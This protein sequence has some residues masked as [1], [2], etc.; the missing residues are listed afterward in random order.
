MTLMRDRQV[1][2]VG[3][4]LSALVWPLFG[5]GRAQADGNDLVLART[6]FN[7]GRKLAASG[8][9]AEACPKFEES[10]RLNPGIGTAFNLAD[11]WDHL[12]RTASAWAKYLDV[13][14]SA[15]VAHQADREKVA[16]DRAAA[17]EPD[18]SR[19]TIEVNPSNTGVEVKNDGAPVGKASWGTPIPTDPGSHVIE[20]TAPGK[21]AWKTTVQVGPR[22]A[23]AS[24]VVPPLEEDRAATPAAAGTGST[25]T[26]AATTTPAGPDPLSTD[27]PAG[28]GDTGRVVG[29]VVGGA[30]V[31][32]LAVGT[33]F[34]LKTKSKTDAASEMCPGDHCK[35]DKE[36][37]EHQA[38]VD[39]A[40][41]ARTVTIVSLAA[42][43]VA[44]A[45][46]LVLVLTS[47]GSSARGGASRPAP[48]L[49][50]A[51]AVASGELGVNFGG[52][53]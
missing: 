43:G 48:G 46:G 31:V 38:L 35:N 27:R 20:A 21:K 15:Q 25:S 28:G 22:G 50:V 30:G 29:F 16:R 33:V 17:L 6:L 26:T 32:G 2:R 53:W 40:K 4:I 3:V 7:D 36:L 41:E 49:V 12:G 1:A 45:T 5:A 42:G 9:F 13:A 44:L 11:C 47:G 51:P 23:K 37:V 24:V 10:A 39:E 8:H 34:G 52:T 14:A 18:L 19:L